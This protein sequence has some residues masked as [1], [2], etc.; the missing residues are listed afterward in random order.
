MQFIL[1]PRSSQL[2]KI[3]S[4][5]LHDTA[6]LNSFHPFIL[7]SQQATYLYVIKVLVVALTETFR[8]TLLS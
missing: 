1:K 7:F 2:D 5:R 3:T 8:F 6:P 4:R